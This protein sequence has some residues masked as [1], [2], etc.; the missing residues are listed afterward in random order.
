MHTHGFHLLLDV[1]LKEEVTDGLVRR[2]EDYVRR[3]FTVVAEARKHFVPHGVTSVL[4]LSESHFT[5]HTYPEHRYVS[6]D[7][8]ICNAGVDLTVVRSEILA[9]LQTDHFESS[10]HRRGQ[11]VEMP[12]VADSQGLEL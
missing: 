7:L 3:R 1:W 5:I 10:L 12:L 4:V 2:L 6:M 8:Y 9:L 11:R